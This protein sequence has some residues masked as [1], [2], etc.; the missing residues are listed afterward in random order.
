[1]PHPSAT[2]PR[3]A[4]PTGRRASLSV[5]VLALLLVLQTLTAPEARAA[6]RATLELSVDGQ[7]A[8][9]RLPARDSATT[10]VPVVLHF[11]GLRAQDAAGEELAE[12]WKPMADAALDA[13]YAVATCACQKNLYGSPES[14]ADMG[15]LWAEIQEAVV[16]DGLY[17]SAE[18]HGGVGALNAI[19]T[20]TLTGVR[21]AYLAMPVVSLR[22]R[23]DDG[24]SEIIESAY[25][26]A[27]D[28]S[29]YDARTA[30]YDP[31]LRPAADLQ[32]VPL[33]VTASPQDTLVPQSAHTE[34]LLRTL[35]GTGQAQ[36]VQASGDHAD[37]SHFVPADLV[38]FLDAQRAR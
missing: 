26:I 17:V 32:G 22:Q 19:T 20:G 25:A 31:A 14:T 24:R 37:P 7:A 18:S 11:Q 29:D 2:F 36:Y 6:G 1:M 10:P 23:Y 16:T 21:G 3:P 5:V 8:Q 9:L 15:A 12:H 35:E 13:G 4:T 34:A 38:A 33:F 30:G 27:D 28:G